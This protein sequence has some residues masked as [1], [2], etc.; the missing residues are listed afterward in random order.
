M[1][2]ICLTAVDP[3]LTFPDLYS[4]TLDHINPRAHGGTDEPHNLRIAHFT[5]NAARQ[6]RV[7]DLTAS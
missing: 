2:G 5:C 3:T 4:A 7:E 1:C 6:D